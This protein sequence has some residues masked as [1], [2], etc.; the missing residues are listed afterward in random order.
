M[1]LAGLTYKLQLQVPKYT[2]GVQCILEGCWTVSDCNAATF[3]ALM[4]QFCTM[5]CA[6]TFVLLQLS[7]S[8][9]CSRRHAIHISGVSPALLAGCNNDVLMLDVPAMQSCIRKNC[10]L[11]FHAF[12]IIVSRFKVAA[13]CIL[14]AC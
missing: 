6:H 7:P 11:V 5:R 14:E 8:K 4:P 1:L 3:A 9:P 12:W 10:Q 2:G 13:Q